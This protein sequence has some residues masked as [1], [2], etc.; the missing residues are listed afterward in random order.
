MKLTADE[1]EMLIKNK[2]F[3]RNNSYYFDVTKKAEDPSYS[4]ISNFTIKVLFAL[5]NGRSGKYIMELTNYDKVTTVFEVTNEEFVNINKFKAKIEPKYIFKGSATHLCTIKEYIFKNI[6]IAIE[7]E[8][9]GHQPKDGFYA[10][11]NGIIHYEGVFIPVDNY[12]IVKHSGASYF[13]PAYSTINNFSADYE[14]QKKFIFREGNL[15]FEEYAKYLY[16]AYGL[17]GAIALVYDIASVFRDIVFR[18][19]NFF[20]HLFK[21]GVKGTAKTTHTS[22]SQALFGIPQTAINLEGVSTEKGLSRKLSQLRNSLIV[23]E[24][25]TNSVSNK[26]IGLLKSIY[27]GIGSEKAQFSNDN[28]THSSPVLSGTIILGNELPTVKSALFDRIILLNYDKGTEHNQYTDEEKKAF[29]SLETER[30]N[31]FGNVL[32]Q[33]LQHRQII[34]KEFYN[35][36]LNIRQHLSAYFQGLNIK[37]AARAVNNISAILVPYK[38]LSEKLQFPFNDD[39]FSDRVIQNLIKQNEI[40]TTVSETHVFWESFQW[41]VSDGK[42]FK[43]KHFNLNNNKLHIRYTLVFPAYKEYCKK[44]DIKSLDNKS[45]LANLT[46]SSAFIK[47]GAKLQSS[48]RFGDCNTPQ[49]TYA[50]DYEKLGIDLDESSQFEFDKEIC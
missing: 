15:T 16:K 18:H 9:L 42:L 17:N 11:S 36:Y 44:N 41:A 45:L 35:T 27:D 12:G 22:L 20:P 3:I 23:L 49:S 1:H 19:T 32:L 37:V 21:F 46:T 13:L 29:E 31:G 25:Y 50:F 38:L 10:Q 48:A 8:T 5:N 33:I 47:S 40:L 2:L 6:G 43:G 7:I 34:E 4:R 14:N 39:W 28:R 24:E 26:T 30:N